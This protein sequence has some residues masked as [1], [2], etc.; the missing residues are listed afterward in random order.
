MNPANATRS[1]LDEI[2]HVV[3]RMR[4]YCAL[5]EHFLEKDHVDGFQS[6]WLHLEE[7]ILFLYK[8]ILLYQMKS[9]C[10]YYRHRGYEF[11]QDLANWNHWD[12]DIKTIGAAEDT[13]RN[14]L[15]QYI[16]VQGKDMLGRLFRHATKMNDELGS[17][18]Q[19]LQDFLFFQKSNVDEKN[20][21]CLRD[22]FVVD[23][24]DDMKK[25]EKNKDTLLSE[26][27]EW[28]FQTE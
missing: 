8:V 10:S 3:S 24:Q 6:I 28:I 20:R 18:H 19:T 23:P 17:F 9:V 26:A 16:N 13:L 27:N 1:N 22:L 12:D 21:Q 5:T 7:R 25:I 15:D 4:W 11:L 14:D 2:A